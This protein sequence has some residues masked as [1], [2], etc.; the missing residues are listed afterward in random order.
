MRALDVLAL[1]EVGDPATLDDLLDRVGGTWHKALS[2]HP[3]RRG[4][5]VRFASRHLIDEREDIIELAAGIGP[6]RVAAADDDDGDAPFATAMGRGAL[7]VSM[8]AGGQPLRLVT[9]HLKSK[10]ISYP[11]GRFNPRDEDER[12][13]YATYA[14]SRRAAGAATLR[15]WLNACIG[16]DGRTL[17]WILLGDMNDE[18][19]AASTQILLGPARVRDG[20]PGERRPDAGD[21]DRLWNLAPRLPDDQR[22]SRVYRGRPELIDHIFVTRALLGQVTAMRSGA[23]PST[24][25]ELTSIDD[26]PQAQRDEPGSDHAPITVTLDI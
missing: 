5:R 3:D 6:V 2:A 20:T 4:I 24:A 26:D 18:P 21:G 10:L 16:A 15:A 12:A 8:V 11:G 1:Q 25:P 14:L 17:R 22:F 13:R 9:A 7:R 23:D 19:A